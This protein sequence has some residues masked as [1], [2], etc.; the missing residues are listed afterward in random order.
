MA[1]LTDVAAIAEIVASIGVILSLIFVGLELSEGNRETSA[2]TAQAAS[3]QTMFLQAEILRYSDTWQKVLDG[4][5]LEDG[6]EN[7]R[8]IVLFDMVMTE[9][10]NRFQQFDMG[11]LEDLRG[12]LETFVALP[13]YDQWKAS[14]GANSKSPEFLELLDGMR[15][16]KTR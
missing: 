14:P 16:A 9:N 1:K 8:G 5:P 7:R 12:N 10:E 13:I 15:P 3:D 4:A 2:A 11:Y 6:E